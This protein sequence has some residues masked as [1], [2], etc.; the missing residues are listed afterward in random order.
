MFRADGHRL[1]SAIRCGGDSCCPAVLNW[2]AFGAKPD[3]DHH[4]FDKPE[5][6]LAMFFPSLDQ[7]EAAHENLM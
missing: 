4:P 2:S 6:R 3:V 1:L 7:G 5:G